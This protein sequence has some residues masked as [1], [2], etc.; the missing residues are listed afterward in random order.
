MTTARRRYTPDRCDDCGRFRPVTWITFWL[1]GYRMK[2]CG[3]C[4]RPYR[5]RIGSAARGRTL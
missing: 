2:V 3:E 4:I 1:N 5:K